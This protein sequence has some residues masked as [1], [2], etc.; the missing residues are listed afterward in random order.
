MVDTAFV[1]QT[2]STVRILPTIAKILSSKFS[3][4]ANMQGLKSP[5]R[6][7]QTRMS[8]KGRT[9]P[10]QALYDAFLERLIFAREEA[11]LTQREVSARM[12]RSHS[13]L[14]QCETGERSI[15]VFELLQ[16]AQLYGKPPQYFLDLD[17][18]QTR[19]V[20]AI[21][22]CQ[23]TLE[24]SQK[25]VCGPQGRHIQIATIRRIEWTLANT[26]A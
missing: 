11:G 7:P 23:R 21:P 26:L 17:R 1:Y 16:I 9:T 10:P 18:P 6:G 20:W 14:S 12:G 4:M 15:E 5:Q 19:K 3:R 8:R 25:P 2:E 22:S 24:A 13:F